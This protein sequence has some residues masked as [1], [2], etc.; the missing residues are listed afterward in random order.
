MNPW[1]AHWSGWSRVIR[2]WQIIVFLYVINIGTGFLLALM[3][4]LQLIEPARLTAIQDAA[5]GV[6]VWMAHELTGL[7][8]NSTGM[9]VDPAQAIAL[10][11]LS[12]ALAIGLGAVGFAPLLAWLTGSVLLGGMILVYSES[13]RPF[14]W[15]RFLW[16][17]WHWC[18]SFLAL[19]LLQVLF[20]LV[21]VVGGAWL[22]L[23]VNQDVSGARGM[24]ILTVAVCGLLLSW[25]AVV[26]EY[27]HVVAVQEGTRNPWQALLGAL[28]FSFRRPLP[29]VSFYS[30]TTLL[31]LFTHILFRMGIFPHMPLEFWPV[32]LVAQQVFILTRL[33]LR[34]Q[35]L[36]G[37]AAL[38]GL[39]L[40]IMEGDLSAGRDSNQRGQG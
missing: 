28:R 3:P 29:L 14:L 23:A 21:V 9:P 27:S 8:P 34:G 26:L 5:Q 6:P 25:G 16:G 22:V 18:A 13:P 19:N 33:S 12:A 30:L 20:I 17:C 7:L 38:S 1:A 39:R 15:K 37:A 11:E 2:Y 32:V 10:Q 40:D 31:I 36:A 35:R 24:A 4:A